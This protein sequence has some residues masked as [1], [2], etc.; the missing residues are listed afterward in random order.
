MG[1][2]NKNNPAHSIAMDEV[3]GFWFNS[4][5]RRM[6]FSEDNRDLNLNAGVRKSGAESEYTITIGGSSADTDLSTPGGR[7]LP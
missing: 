3:F 5:P 1:L 6:M 2:V 7:V 4:D